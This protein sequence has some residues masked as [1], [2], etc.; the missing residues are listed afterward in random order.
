M[1]VHLLRGIKF[2][3]LNAQTCIDW[4]YFRIMKEVF[5]EFEVILGSSMRIIYVFN[6][7]P[8]QRF[9][10]CF[11]LQHGV[12][13]NHLI[14]MWNIQ[15]SVGSVSG[16]WSIFSVVPSKLYT[17]LIV[18]NGLWVWRSNPVWLNSTLVFL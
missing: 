5:W 11:F 18:N 14:H 2:T 12:V 10:W 13:L 1:C 16:T 3:C 9:T 17:L 15:E 8:I 4:T 7:L 6:I